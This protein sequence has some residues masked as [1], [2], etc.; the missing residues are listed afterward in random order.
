[1]QAP[2]H[3]TFPPFTYDAVAF[4]TQAVT[5]IILWCTG[6]SPPH[7]IS[8]YPFP[9]YLGSDRKIDSPLPPDT[10]LTVV[11]NP[12]AKENSHLTSWEGI[13][14]DMFQPTKHVYHNPPQGSQSATGSASITT[15]L[16]GATNN[17]YGSLA[18]QPRKYDALFSKRAGVKLEVNFKVPVTVQNI[19]D[20]ITREGLQ[21]Y[22][23]NPAGSGCLCWQLQLLQ[24]FVQQGWIEE[25]TLHTFKEQLAAGAKSNPRILYPPVV[26]QF[27]NGPLN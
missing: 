3:K 22:K 13:S 7:W 14:V 12:R 6:G 25:T 27:Y 9:Q 2:G 5:G 26:G 24:R 1:M 17:L 20:L 11:S 19:V 8:S 21:Y 10:A 4:H 23:F 18:I 16:R 15:T